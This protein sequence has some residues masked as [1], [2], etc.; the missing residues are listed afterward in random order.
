MNII[1]KIKKRKF[2]N[3]FRKKNFNND[4][5]PG[6]IFNIE[7]VTIGKKTYGTLYV[8]NDVEDAYLHIGNYCSIGDNTTFLLGIDHPTNY[9]STF[10]FKVK[11]CK[12]TCVES[13]SKG[14][15]VVNDDVWI[16]YGATILSGVN[17]G[18][19]AIIGA[20]SVVSKDVPPYAIVGGVP[21]RVIRYRFEK[22]IIDELIKVDFSKITD[23]TIETNIDKLY[24]EIKDISQLA[25]LPKKD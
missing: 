20:N 22:N 3:E 8:F 23:N 15:I 9:L 18:Q 12:M 17:I 5:F 10:P 4:T 14:N 11:S 21:A 2:I 7:N 19:G 16:G 24:K 25:W 1:K 6:N 13:I